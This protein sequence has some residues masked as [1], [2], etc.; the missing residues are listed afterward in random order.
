MEPTT[1]SS[2]INNGLYLGGILSLITVLVYAVNLDLFTE[3]WLGILLFVLVFVYGIVSAVKSRTILGGFISFK[4]AFT[5]YFVTIAI[6]TLISTVL[7]IVIFTIIDPEA[8]TYLNEQ[9]LVVTK[10]TMQRFGMPEEAMQA[11]LEEASQKNNFSLGM[12]SQG[13]V[14]RLAFYA[15]IGLIVAL[16][17]KKTDNKEA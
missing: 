9:I 14:F 4:Q 6:G 13:F 8:A 17:V 10:Q 7:G 1:K 12:Q 11:A 5:S 16:I 2:V 15:V 3:W